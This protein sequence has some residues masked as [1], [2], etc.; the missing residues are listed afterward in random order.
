MHAACG[1][2][3]AHSLCVTKAGHIYSFGDG[4]FGT[5]MALVGSLDHHALIDWDAGKLGHGNNERYRK[6]ERIQFEF[7]G[8]GVKM[9]WCGLQTSACLTNH[10]ALYTWG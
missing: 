10:G 3:D 4:D 6:P 8:S 2:G 9:A 1:L 5:L 7:D